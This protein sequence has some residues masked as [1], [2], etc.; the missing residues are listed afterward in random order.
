MLW[1]LRAVMDEHQEGHVAAPAG[2]QGARAG[3]VVDDMVHPAVAPAL[4]EQPGQAVL[5]PEQPAAQ[6][7]GPA[8]EH[9]GHHA[10]QTGAD[11]GRHIAGLAGDQAAPGQEEQA[12]GEDQQHRHRVAEGLQRGEQGRLAG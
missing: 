10:D 5:Q 7:L 9:E 6:R 4:A 2:E 1:P 3:H 12:E 8:G 11:Q